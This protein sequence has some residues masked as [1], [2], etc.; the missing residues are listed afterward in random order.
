[1]SRETFVRWLEE[2]SGD[3]T[4]AV[5]GK[6]ANLGE[7]ANLDVPVL[8]GFT[9]TASA[10][11]CYVEETGIHAAIESELDGRTRC[12]RHCG[13]S[14]VAGSGSGARFRR[15]PCRRNSSRR[16]SS[17]T[18]NWATNSGSPTRRSPSGAPRRPRTSRG[19]VRR[20][21]GDVPER[22]WRDGVDR[23]DQTLLRFAVYRSCDRL[24]R[25]QRLRPL[26]RQTGLCSP[27]DGAGRPGLVGRPIHARS[28]HRIRRGR[29][30]RGC[31]W[32]RRTDRPGRR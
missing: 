23:V 2:L 6:S 12:R 17:G 9:T 18:P 11:D 22:R 31:L 5:G 30:D 14:S 24:S 19:V 3:N 29:H 20:P 32:L 4:D 10:Y 28:R 16:S 8:P 1:M 26:R 7:L 13:T 25:E 15:R 27:E 21:A